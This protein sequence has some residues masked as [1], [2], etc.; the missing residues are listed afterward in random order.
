MAYIGELFKTG[1]VC[2]SKGKYQFASYL[3][4]TNSPAPTAEER[5]IPL[6]VGDR[7]PPVNSADKGAWWRFIG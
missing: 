6:D 4:G 2:S 7:F 5:V 3:D 1:Q